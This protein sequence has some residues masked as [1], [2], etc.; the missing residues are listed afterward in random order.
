[1]VFCGFDYGFYESEVNYYSVVFNE[2]IYGRYLELRQ[3]GRQLNSNL[4]IPDLGTLKGIE[5]VR[6]RLVDMGADLE[7]AEGEEQFAYI[8][9]YRPYIVEYRQ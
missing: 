1:M 6:I 7:G 5:S 3:F 4:L 8:A 2:V 9:V